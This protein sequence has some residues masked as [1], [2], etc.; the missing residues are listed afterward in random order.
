MPQD[1]SLQNFRSCFWLTFLTLKCGLG[2]G[3]R[4]AETGLAWMLSEESGRLNADDQLN[5]RKN[6]SHVGK[7]HQCLLFL[8][9]SRNKNLNFQNQE[10]KRNISSCLAS[11]RLIIKKQVNI[12]GLSFLLLA[13]Q[14]FLSSFTGWQRVTESQ[15]MWVNTCS[16]TQSGRLCVRGITGQKT[17]QPFAFQVAERTRLPG[18]TLR[19]LSFI[20]SRLRWDPLPQDRGH[21]RLVSLLSFS[22][23]QWLLVL[24]TNT[25]Q[26][27]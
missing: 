18:R 15:V 14:H 17:R 8:E 2:L 22:L 9:K 25:N 10:R 3:V 13:T 6:E 21:A 26:K 27:I 7:C 24:F 11:K 1:K 12:Q 19:F 23:I 4:E 20:R 16:T 5:F